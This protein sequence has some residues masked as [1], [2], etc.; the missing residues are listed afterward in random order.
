MAFQSVL[1]PQSGGVATLHFYVA[2]AAVLDRF[3]VIRIR[4]LKLADPWNS[5][6]NWNLCDRAG[7]QQTH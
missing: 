2:D 1:V 6:A 4:F 5:D 7:L 3:F